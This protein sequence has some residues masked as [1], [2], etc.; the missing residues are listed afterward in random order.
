ML[1]A[2]AILLPSDNGNDVPPAPVAKDNSIAVLPFDAITAGQGNDWMGQGISEDLLNLL[3]GID[4]L[5]VAG[6][7]S[8]FRPSLENM[9]IGA[10]GRELNVRYVLDGSI[11]RSDDRL[12]IA[13]QLIDTTTGFNLWSEV[14]NRTTSDVFTIQAEIAER[15]V[16]ALK[17]T[18]PIG[19]T[20]EQNARTTDSVD[21]YDYYLQARS[22]L[23]GPPT[24]DAI[25]NAIR[26]YERALEFDPAYGEAHAGLCSARNSR[27]SATTRRQ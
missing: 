11:R 12:R 10:I 27:P 7:T 26:F 24:A 16:K 15:V 14:Y 9:D 22:F 2:I 5:E 18:T 6:R 17:L 1:T 19:L 25:R 13:A 3:A 20:T 8:S 23:N 21:A 4:G